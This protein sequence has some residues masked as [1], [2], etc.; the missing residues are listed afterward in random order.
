MTGNVVVD[1]VQTEEQ[2]QRTPSPVWLIA[3]GGLAAIV[4]F[5]LP[6]QPDAVPPTSS[7]TIPEVILPEDR[8]ERLDLPWRGALTDVTVLED[9]R[10]VAVGDGPR[11]WI[12][13]GATEWSWMPGDD[14]IPAVPSD[15]TGFGSG[16]VA[17]GTARPGD[18]SRPDVFGDSPM[19]AAAWVS[20]DLE[21]WQRVWPT[22]D[23]QTGLEGVVAAD[24]LL[25][26]WGWRGAPQ[27][28][29]PSGSALLLV[30]ADGLEWQEVRAPTLDARIYGVERARGRGWWAMGYE[31]GRPGLW[32]SDD[33]LS[34]EALATRALPFGWAM[35]DL[36]DP[37]SEATPMVATLVDV[38]NGR[39][40]RWQLQADGEWSALGEA[41]GG[42]TM[43]TSHHVEQYGAG[44]GRLWILEGEQWEEVDLDGEIRAVE[45]RVAVGNHRI[46][47]SLWVVDAEEVT[48]SLPGVEGEGWERIVDLGEGESAGAWPVGDGWVVGASA[49]GW[50]FVDETGAE[51]IDPGWDQ[52]WRVDRVGEEWVAVPSMLWSRDGRNWEV[53]G[54]AWPTGIRAG[55]DLLAVR[56]DGGTVVAVHGTAGWMWSVTLSEDRGRSWE[57][58]ADPAPATPLWNVI[59]TADGFAATA[60]R[61]RGT[62]AVVT[63]RDGLRWE[64]LEGAR[65]LLPTSVPAAITAE[66]TLLLLDTGEELEVP[67]R[68]IR[69]LVRAGNRL[70]MMA[71]GLL[72]VGPGEW[73]RLPLDPVH[74]I[75][76]VSVAPLVIDGRIMAVASDGTE[77]ALYEWTG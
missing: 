32:V 63:S 23:L 65:Y 13:E 67:R 29:S 71:G 21:T 47:P 17:V 14:D 39:V 5:L 34:W 46:Q 56:D 41:P 44:S 64:D 3:L 70:V 72:W 73:E 38:G 55:S 24:D 61:Q 66:G 2:S 53:R 74:G 27:P 62:E 6:G 59:P 60:A 4:L 9:G 1:D 54:D 69:E 77:V 15:V 22:T 26:A 58:A 42:P 48:Y 10:Y 37:P 76:A 68:D 12:S 18:F 30:S 43:V 33:L 49:R 36:E 25:V 52:L 57:F 35:V 40:R 11:F 20:P 28:F 7:L 75:P 50:W 31:I 8:W 19:R 45:G 51:A 16:A